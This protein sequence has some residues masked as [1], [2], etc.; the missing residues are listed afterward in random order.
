MKFIG[1]IPIFYVDVIKK[2]YSIRGA[3]YDLFILINKRYKDDEGLLAHEFE[4]VKQFWLHGLLIHTALYRFCKY[5]R[6]MC[7]LKAYIKQWKVNKGNENLL[8]NYIT[9]IHLGYNLSYSRDYIKNK[10]EK[11]TKKSI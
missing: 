6:F 1:I 2:D 7:E 10:F 9:R 4:H 5:Y 3:S 8:E 11:Y